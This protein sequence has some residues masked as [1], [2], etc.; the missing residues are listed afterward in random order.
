MAGTRAL[1]HQ[2]KLSAGRA[3]HM[4]YTSSNLAGIQA[5]VAAGMGLSIL[6]EMAIQADDRVLTAKDGFAPIDRTEVA[7]V[8][9]PDASPATLR[10]ADRLSEFCNGVQ[11][12]AA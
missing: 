8:A 4:A 2:Q 6:S 10:L 12:R 7:L 3:W 5:A 1:D 11:T 9:S